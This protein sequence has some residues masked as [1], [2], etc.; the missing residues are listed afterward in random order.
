MTAV[1]SRQGVMVSGSALDIRNSR[2]SGAIFEALYADG[3]E[4]TIYNSR[5]GNTGRSVLSLF[6]VELGGFG[7]RHRW[8]G[9]L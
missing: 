7:N 2:V 4:V 1:S 9:G 6:D 3:S 5:P 8:N